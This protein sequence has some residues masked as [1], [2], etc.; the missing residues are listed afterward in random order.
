MVI[1]LFRLH[2]KNKEQE[3]EQGVEQR[4]TETQHL[5][6]KSNII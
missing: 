6:P 2:K 1:F 4:R 5:K 3:Q